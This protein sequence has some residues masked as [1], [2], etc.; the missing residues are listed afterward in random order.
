M[1][2]KSNGICQLCGTHGLLTDDHIPQKS[3][4][5]K[6]IRGQI[7]NFN[8][9]K[10]CA[11]CN[12][13]ACQEDEL[14]KVLVG[15]LASSWWDGKLWNSTNSTLDKNRRL[16]KEIALNTR[17]EQ[18]DTPD[19]VR[20]V[21]VL[22]LEGNIRQQFLLAME[23]I[24]KGLFF[25]EFREVLTLTRIISLYHPDA[26]HPNKLQYIRSHFNPSNWKEVN[27]G[28]CKYVFT[29]LANGEIVLYLILFNSIKLHYAI[30]KQ[31]T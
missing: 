12:N 9:V 19:G 20:E 6:Q 3:L 26:I 1:A 2:K 21:P 25:Q 8:T 29:E 17:T 27:G 4:Y 10:A 7:P 24:V 18:V 5:P 14:L 31:A 11:K 22:T 28:T 30:I 16:D 23:R 13:G 15:N